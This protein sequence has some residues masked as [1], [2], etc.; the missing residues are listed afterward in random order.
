MKLK[1]TFLTEKNNWAVTVL[2][3]ALLGFTWMQMHI[4][5][6]LWFVQFYSINC[7]HVRPHTLLHSWSH[8]PFLIWNGVCVAM[9]NAWSIYFPSCW[10]FFYCIGLWTH[11]FTVLLNNVCLSVNHL[12]DERTKVD[13]LLSLLVLFQVLSENNSHSRPARLHPDHKLTP[14]IGKITLNTLLILIL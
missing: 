14:G 5:L 7:C 4:C 11:I 3:P 13:C 1:W 2:F 12:H 8:F 10:V 9:L 6:N